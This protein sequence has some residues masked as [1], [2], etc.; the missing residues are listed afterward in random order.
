MGKRTLQFNHC[1]DRW[2]TDGGYQTYYTLIVRQ[3]LLDNLYNRKKSFHKKL[4][5]LLQ[6][7]RGKT[8]RNHHTTE[9]NETQIKKHNY[10]YESSGTQTHSWAEQNCF[11][12]A[13]CASPA[14]RS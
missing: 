13:I 2:L 5:K 7:N 12:L 14:A 10:A 6:Q 11:Q 3:I 8:R 9:R 4:G 1:F